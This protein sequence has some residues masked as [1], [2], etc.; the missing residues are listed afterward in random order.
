MFLNAAMQVVQTYEIC[1]ITRPF[2]RSSST[3]QAH[4]AR[5]RCQC[6]TWCSHR[7]AKGN[8]W[9]CRLCYRLCCQTCIHSSICNYCRTK[10][11]DQSQSK[12]EAEERNTKRRR[13]EIL[14]TLNVKICREA[15]VEWVA[16]DV[17]YCTK[18]DVSWK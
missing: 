12:P 5:P 1:I 16:G 3:T 11:M 7:P 6:K 2:V 9:A 15:E 10:G 17:Q 8:R 13:I 18:T 4:M 14:C